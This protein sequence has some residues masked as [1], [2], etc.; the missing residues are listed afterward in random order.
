MI[1]RLMISLRK[2]AHLQGSA[3]SMGESAL[4]R[5]PG[6]ET[7]SMIRFAPDRGALNR[8][9]DDPSLSPVSPGA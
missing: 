8:R 6:R 9:D 5:D 3:W 1:T 2:A 7:F 4:S